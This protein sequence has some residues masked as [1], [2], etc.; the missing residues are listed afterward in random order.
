MTARVEKI[1]REK[2]AQVLVVSS[3]LVCKRGDFIPPP[4]LKRLKRKG[5]N[6][7]PPTEKGWLVH[8]YQ[9]ASPKTTH[10]LPK[11]ILVP[12]DIE[13]SL[14]SMVVAI[15]RVE[16]KEALLKMIIENN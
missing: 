2:A 13:E 15:E 5:P 1:C 10:S 3:V 6:P 9:A 16:S 7:G 8:H 11:A 4:P 12:S 14:Q